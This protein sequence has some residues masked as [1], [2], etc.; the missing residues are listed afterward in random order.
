MTLVDALVEE[1]DDAGVWVKDTLYTDGAS[2][3]SYGCDNPDCCPI[4]GAPISDEL[5]TMMAAEFAGVGA[6]MAPSGQSLV[7]DV[8]R[9]AARVQEVAKHLP[10]VEAPTEGLETWRDRRDR[11]AALE[12]EPVS[13]G[14]RAGADRFGGCAGA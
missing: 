8:A 5:R 4:A 9:E 11:F 6:A 1:L 13:G 12:P 10:A 2:R 3:W 14:H 7:D